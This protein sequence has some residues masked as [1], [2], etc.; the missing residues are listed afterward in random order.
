MSLKEAT[1]IY[2][3]NIKDGRIYHKDKAYSSVKGYLQGIHLREREF[4]GETVFYWY[5][6]LKRET[7]ED[8]YSIAL[9]YNSGVAKSIFNCIASLESFSEPITIQPYEK[10]GYTKVLVKTGEIKL[11][12]K[13]SELPPIQEVKVGDRIVKDDSKRM[14]FFKDIVEQINTAIK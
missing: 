7:A 11:S 8:I 13:Y 1:T 3:L 2:Y 12:W 6:N 4:N 9:P 10:D 5:I 14:Q